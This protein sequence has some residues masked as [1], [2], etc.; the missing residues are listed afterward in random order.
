MGFK[1]K[2][3]L[4]KVLITVL[5][6]STAFG[7]FENML[8]HATQMYVLFGLVVYQLWIAKK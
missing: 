4:V 2:R 8:A 1:M 5:A 7:L 3:D 6:A